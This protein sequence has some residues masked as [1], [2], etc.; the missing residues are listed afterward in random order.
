MFTGTLIEDL[1]TAVEKAEN[2]SRPSIPKKVERKKVESLSS[3]TIESKIDYL[4]KDLQP[5]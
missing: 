2:N 5:E 4:R 3:R 1:L